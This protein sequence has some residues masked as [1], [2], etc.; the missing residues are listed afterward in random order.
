MSAISIIA[1]IATILAL[2]AATALMT[3]LLVGFVKWFPA[4]RRTTDNL[5][6]ASVHLVSTSQNI[7]QTTGHLAK[8]AGDFAENS[9]DISRNVAEAARN[10]AESS[11]Y[12]RTAVRLLELL[13]PAGR[14]VQLTETGLGRVIEWLKGQGSG[15]ASRIFRR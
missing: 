9:G 15:F 2:L 13:G 10:I 3:A 8:I 1:G 7:E 14:A 5:E 11:G 4:F 6:R 12:I